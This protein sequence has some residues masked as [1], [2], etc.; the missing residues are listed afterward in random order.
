[1]GATGNV[2]QAILDSI[3]ATGIHKVSVITRSES[4]SSSKLPDSVIIHRG[5]YTDE[6]FLV[7]ALAGQDILILAVSFMSYSAQDPIIRAAAKAGVPW[8]LPT[9]Y[10]SDPEASLN[11][12]LPLNSHKVPFREL[13]EELGTSNWIGLS[14]NPWLDYCLLQGGFVGIDIKQKTAQLYGNGEVKANFT[15]L[16]RVGS[17]AAALLSLPDTE[18]SKFKNRFVYTSSVRVSQRDI[19]E[20]ALRVTGTT[21]DQWTVEY[22]DTAEAIH[23]LKERMA[24]GDMMAGAQ[25][26]FALTFSDGLGGDFNDKVVDYEGL[27]G[28]EKEESLDDIVKQVVAKLGA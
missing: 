7:A 16:P 21:E 15:A 24:S 11:K 27:L 14:T 6:S 10:G 20:S 3:L 13:I 9:E 17:T 2:G 1:M 12:D 28:L 4:S 23:G 26:L 5:S 22:K 25:L 18:L 8:I 19:L